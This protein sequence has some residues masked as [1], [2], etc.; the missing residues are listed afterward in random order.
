MIPFAPMAIRHYFQHPFS[1]TPPQRRVLAD[2]LKEYDPLDHV[3]AYYAFDKEDLVPIQTLPP[4]LGY[5][6]LVL[7]LIGEG[8]LLDEETL[9]QGVIWDHSRDL[10]DY[11][12]HLAAVLQSNAPALYQHR[13]KP[14]VLA[15]DT[16]RPDLDE[17]PYL[18]QSY[19]YLGMVDTPETRKEF[20]CPLE[21]PQTATIIHFPGCS[22]SK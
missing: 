9:V 14:F 22:T 13:E 11:Q 10:G 3:L 6:T 18:H 21:R 17:D 15:V 8:Y 7:D 19:H 20:L 5:Q 4:L 2:F 1:T 16:H 12:N